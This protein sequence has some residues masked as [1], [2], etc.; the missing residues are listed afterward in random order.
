MFYKEVKTRV[1]V[2]NL[3]HFLVHRFSKSPPKKKLGDSKSYAFSLVPKARPKPLIYLTS[4]A[5]AS[6]ARR[7][8]CE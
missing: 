5:L 7:M 2:R 8:V 4:F 3:P 6:N 1:P